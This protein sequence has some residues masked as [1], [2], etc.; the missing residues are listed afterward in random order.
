[1][2]FSKTNYNG[3]A[4]PFDL[5]VIGMTGCTLYSS[6]DLLFPLTNVLGVA[7]W[8]VALPATSSG[9]TFYNQAIVA[10]PSANSLGLIVSDAGEA[11][12]G[13]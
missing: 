7:S 8:S 2:G 4:L 5:S 13:G 10:D 6:G 9:T 3:L 11:N 12:V 1:M